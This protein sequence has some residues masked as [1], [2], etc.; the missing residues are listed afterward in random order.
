[1]GRLP[2]LPAHGR[3]RL[4]AEGRNIVQV[5]RWLGITLPASR[6]IPM[7]ISLRATSGAPLAPLQAGVAASSGACP[8]VHDR[9]LIAA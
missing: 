1:M 5:Q 2:H 8:L 9:Q 4:F 7:C 3:A 6:L